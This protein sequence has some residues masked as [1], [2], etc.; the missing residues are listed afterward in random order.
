MREDGF[1]LDKVL[2]TTDAAFVPT[3][4]GPA[5]S[6][7]VGGSAPT[8]SITRSGANTVITYTGTLVSSPTVGGTYSPVVG[9]T[10]PYTVPTPTVGNQYYRAQQ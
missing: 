6:Q 7:L 5:E 4:T 2:L 9:A 1:L 8:I 10:S 3:G